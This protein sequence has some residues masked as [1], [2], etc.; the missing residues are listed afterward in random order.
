[1]A[2]GDR[3]S[4]T[5][6]GGSGASGTRVPMTTNFDH[7]ETEPGHVLAV[8]LRR[9][10]ER[11]KSTL[12]RIGWASG[13]F[14][15]SRAI[16]PAPTTSKRYA[17]NW[18][19]STAN[20]TSWCS[21]GWSGG[22]HAEYAVLEEMLDQFLG[23]VC[24]P[25]SVGQ[26]RPAGPLSVPELM[27]E[28]MVYRIMWPTLPVAWLSPIPEADDAAPTARDASPHCADRPPDEFARRAKSIG[29]K[30]RQ[31]YRRSRAATGGS[32]NPRRSRPD[33]PLILTVKSSVAEPPSGTD[34]I[35]EAEISQVNG[36][37]PTN[38]FVPSRTSCL[39]QR[40]KP[41]KT[42]VPPMTRSMTG[43]HR[44][45][46]LSMCSSFPGNKADPAP[47]RIGR[48]QPRPRNSDR[49]PANCHGKADD[50]AESAGR[51]RCSALPDAGG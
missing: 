6:V 16:L 26:D 36:I 33:V 2:L 20:P 12:P 15:A 28:S 44:R 5:D 17:P 25:G 11:R 43:H 9:E 10:G 51:E 35:L 18:K 37:H 40:P 31:G 24:G 42:I 39:S 13:V 14:A 1:M 7:I 45:Q 34:V 3:H 49:P 50:F 29:T 23:P 21:W 48:R 8:T 30:Q 4:V 19:R 47:D 27:R 32:A 22:H 46:G 38:C 41:E